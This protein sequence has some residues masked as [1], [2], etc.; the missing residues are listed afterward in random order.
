VYED[1]ASVMNGLAHLE[2][3]SLPAHGGE[4]AG[5]G[6]EHDDEGDG[7]GAQHSKP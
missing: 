3:E 6:Q 1:S 7:T 4:L 2:E 5:L